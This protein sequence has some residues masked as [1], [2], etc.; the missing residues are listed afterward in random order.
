MRTFQ[1]I[2]SELGSKLDES[3]K[4]ETT[5]STQSGFPLGK[6][7][8]GTAYIKGENFNLLINKT[9]T[10]SYLYQVGYP[11]EAPIGRTKKFLDQSF[12]TLTSNKEIVLKELAKQE[13]QEGGFWYNALAPKIV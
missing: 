2:L 5:A 8:I 9:S 10:S 7:V 4:K 13:E 6:T 1:E 11:G 3:F 12:I